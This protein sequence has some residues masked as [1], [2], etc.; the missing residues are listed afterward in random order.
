MRLCRSTVLLIALL[1]LTVSIAY[2]H[3]GG[4]DQNGGHYNRST[5]VYHCH[6]PYCVSPS[7]TPAST[8]PYTSPIRTPAPDRPTGDTLPDWIR[9]NIVV[10][11]V[12]G[13]IVVV[14]LATRRS[15]R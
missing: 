10:I 2:A 4:L 13:I 8:I 1:S 12:G 11:V 9:D 14:L 7:R 15:K 5:G 3:S 6:R